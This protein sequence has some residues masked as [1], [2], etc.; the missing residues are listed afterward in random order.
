MSI[1]FFDFDGT[2]IVRDSGVICAVPCIRRG[3]L[4]PGIGARLIGTY[5]L[6]KMGLRTRGDAQ[7]VGF[8]CYRGKS[9]AEL[10]AIMQSLHDEHLR[11][12][13]SEPLRERVAAHRAA[14][15]HVVILTAS[16]FF[17]AEPF[18]AEHGIDELVGT[19]VGFVDG[20][21]SGAVDGTILDGAAKLAAAERCAA[22]RGVSLDAC[23]FYTDH[24]ADLP[25]LEVVGT[26][27]VVGESR[28]LNRIAESR[29][30]KKIGHER[31]VDSAFA[32]TPNPE[33]AKKFPF[34]VLIPVGGFFVLLIV[35]FLAIWQFL[36]P[37][38][39]RVPV[40]YSDF[41]SE[42]HAGRVDE[43]RI[44]DREYTF[45]A[46]ATEGR[47]AVVKEAIGPVPDQAVIDSLKPDDPAK[48]LP[49]IYFEK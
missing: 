37:A 4:G 1:A 34:W 6:S 17:F 26:P 12:F 31:V 41:L 40:A 7:R 29:G 8:E 28:A 35:A 45:R 13:V 43:I 11:R 21:C 18:C 22:A 15:D 23:T 36:T 16:A 47:P 20:I 14:G 30:W 27:V 48:P 19:Q 38:E 3:L 2:L 46:L 9:L 49:K 44:H 33:P 25:L 5:L 10:R 39:R 24:V 32:M 42:V